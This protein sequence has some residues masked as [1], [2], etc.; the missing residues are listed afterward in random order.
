MDTK[1]C[2]KCGESKPLD[3]YYKRSEAAG[4][5]L[6]ASCKDCKRTYYKRDRRWGHIKE[7]YGLSKSDY[8]ARYEEQGGRCGICAREQE[9]LAV[10]HCH[11]TGAVRGLL[12]KQCN[13]AIGLLGDNLSGVLNAVEYL[14]GFNESSLP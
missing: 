1:T 6:D 7:R 8:Q 5:G 13:S 9:V 2:T 11:E 4:G 10:D 3:S 14:R 12:C